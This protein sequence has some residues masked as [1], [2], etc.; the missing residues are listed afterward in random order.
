MPWQSSPALFPKDWE[1]LCIKVPCPSLP[2]MGPPPGSDE[3]GP[4]DQPAPRAEAKLVLSPCTSV[5]H[6]NEHGA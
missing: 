3:D 4:G 1:L 2:L 6:S 5:S